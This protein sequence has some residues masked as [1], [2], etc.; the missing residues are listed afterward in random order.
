MKLPVAIVGA[1]PV[2]LAAAAHLWERGETPLVLEAGNSVGHSVLNWAHVR[3]F[4]PWR[5]NMDAAS[6]RLLVSTGWIEPDADH[7]PTG[8]EIVKHYLE[9][10]AQR[11]PLAPHIK[12]N[13]R[14]ISISRRGLDKVRSKGRESQ[15][16]SI[17]ATSA[18]GEETEFLA[19]AVIDASGTWRT[20]NPMGAIGEGC[21]RERI[22][23]GIP[24]VLGAKRAD[25]AGSE[26]VVV[27]SGHSAFN[28]VLDLLTLKEDVPE[29]LIRWVMRKQSLDKVFGGGAA[30]ALPARGAL[31]QRARD[32]VAS[33]AVELITPFTINQLSRTE[34]GQALI[35]GELPTGPK[36]VTTDRIVV[37]TGFRPDLDILRE[38]R[39]EM[40]PALESVR[41]LGPLIDPNVHSCGSVRPHGARELAHPE[42]DFY[43][44]GMK[45]YGRAPTFLMATGYEQVR[46]V[47]AELTGDHEA[48]ERV[49]LDLPETG[50]CSLS[51][52]ENASEAD[53]EPTCCGET[54]QN[55]EQSCCGNSAEAI[56][57]SGPASD[58]TASCN[59]TP[60][61]PAKSPS[62]CCG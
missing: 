29:T 52:N 49:E 26:I 10:L 50:V 20:P 35:K 18:E 53:A 11:T 41:A 48:A 61:K 44:V 42:K 17:R 46:S 32:A 2:G 28:V 13:T 57:E 31:G 60:V 19:K 43:I 5:Y 33:G 21:V 27:G 6:K 34:H 24:D 12:L 40:D 7:L 59:S 37:T 47:V 51:D 23:Y 16:F 36:S 39:L 56:T 55:K 58:C 8:A 45:S 15:P 30:D 14:V 25:Y 22:D 38:V 4:S 9:P 1:G 3:M 54:S 62:A